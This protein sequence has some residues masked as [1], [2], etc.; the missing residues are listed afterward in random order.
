M[1][2]SILDQEYY[3]KWQTIFRNTINKILGL[4]TTLN[5]M[6]VFPVADGD[7]GTNI[8]LTLKPSIEIAIKEKSLKHFFKCFA[9]ECL[10]NSRGNS[11]VILSRY[12]SGF[13]KQIQDNKT[14]DDFHNAFKRA[15]D[16]A[17]RVLENPQEGTMLSIM[18][19]CTAKNNLKSKLYFKTIYESC[20]TTILNTRH[21]L[22]ILIEAGT[23]D[24]GA[25]AFLQFIESIYEELSQE[26]SLTIKHFIDSQNLRLKGYFPDSSEKYKSWRKREE[27][28]ESNLNSKDLEYRYC[29][30]FIIQNASLAEK[31]LGSF[32]TLG[33][34]YIHAQSLDFTKVHIHTNNVK[35]VIE[36][37]L[38]FG[39]VKKIKVDDMQ[40]QHD[41]IF[42]NENLELTESGSAFLAFF[43]NIKLFELVN[44][45]GESI[46]SAYL[47]NNYQK[48]YNTIFSVI[49]SINKKNIILFALEDHFEYQLNEIV[50]MSYK[51][52]EIF[53][54]NTITEIVFSA[55]NF[56]ST[57]SIS[58]NISMLKIELEQ[59]KSLHIVSSSDEKKGSN[60]LLVK[61]GDSIL[62]SG[63]DLIELFIYS[64]NSLKPSIGSF[65]TIYYGIK[66]SN[67]I[68]Y[69][70]K[71]FES[72]FSEIESDWINIE[73]SNYHFI[74]SLE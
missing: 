71:F 72:N 52:V 4:Q 21:D 68:N 5:E 11:G 70:K 69:Y 15:Y 48:D 32:K 49:S 45:F 7:T 27:S 64:I 74:L 62:K 2:L 65:L 55:L 61:F 67:N 8:V 37:A 16:E 59:L 23:I 56:Q 31:E 42:S 41:H 24:S 35:D 73:D 44:S 54:C 38:N 39:K 66:V 58:D 47:E 43:P 18:Q 29:T 10:Q 1:N 53:H 60:E 22:D 20:V 25:L 46:Y 51:N 63:E 40:F 57:L 9:N 3:L 30:E 19:V 13:S 33:N 14:I 6:N 17:Y 36:H 34:S 28:I 26:D 12:F 50:E